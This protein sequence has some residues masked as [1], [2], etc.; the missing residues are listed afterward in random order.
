MPP[1]IGRVV[2]QEE[3]IDLSKITNFMTTVMYVRTY[4]GNPK[5]VQLGFLVNFADGGIG[6]HNPMDSHD[7]LSLDSVDEVYLLPENYRKR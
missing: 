4:G 6:I 5:E 7:P 3:N 2:L 1:I